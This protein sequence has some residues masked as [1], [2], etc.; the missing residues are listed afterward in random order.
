MQ[1]ASLNIQRGFFVQARGIYVLHIDVERISK[2]K[3]TSTCQLV[4]AF[5]RRPRQYRLL[6]EVI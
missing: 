3:D 4:L 5:A 1:K 6:T 2:R